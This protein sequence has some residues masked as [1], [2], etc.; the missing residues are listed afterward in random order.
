M[1]ELFLISKNVPELEY[2]ADFEAYGYG[3]HSAYGSDALEEFEVLNLVDTLN[4][5]RL[6]DLGKEIA[7]ILKKHIS[8]NELEMIKDIKQLC[9]DLNTDEI[10]ALVYYTYPEMT[11]E[12]LVKDRIDK[13][14][15][16]C[17]EFTKE[18]KG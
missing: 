13:K 6:T 4:G 10:L 9:N 18:G 16:H 2:E 8:K 7:A 14:K 11:V 1:K 3:P 15:K 5:Y 12:S 17:P